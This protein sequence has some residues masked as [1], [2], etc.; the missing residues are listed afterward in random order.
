MNMSL[1]SIY[2]RRFSVPH[3]R[4]VL[5][6]LEH[7]LKHEK[8]GMEP[9]TQIVG[10]PALSFTYDLKQSL[11][12]QLSEAQGVREGEGELEVA[13]RRLDE[14]AAG[15]EDVTA[16]ESEGPSDVDDAMTG[17]DDGARV[18]GFVASDVLGNQF[19]GF[20][21]FEGISTYKRH[22]KKGGSVGASGGVLPKPHKDSKEW[23][24][25]SRR[26]WYPSSSAG[27]GVSRER[28]SQ[29]GSLRAQSGAAMSAAENFLKQ[30]RG[31]T[32]PVERKLRVQSMVNMGDM[33]MY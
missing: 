25:G 17:G 26:D 22:W 1:C 14:D 10:E 11:Y 21:L 33:G 16:K 29:F 8:M 32:V 15:M 28:H 30:A 2:Y 13:V 31:E 6:A 19:F 4:L 18:S 9:N 23:E 12:E 24:P 3:D 5:D 7:D 27:N 20:P